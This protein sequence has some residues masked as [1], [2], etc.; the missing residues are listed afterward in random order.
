MTRRT[1]V[2]GA[3]ATAA[4]GALAGLVDLPARATPGRAR[5]PISLPSPQQVR[6]DVQRMV[7]FGPRLT[8]SAPHQHFVAWLEREL[9]AAGARLLPCDDY[10]YERWTAE[11]VGLEV[12]DGPG[13]GAVRVA[14]SFT[15]AQETPAGGVTGPLVYGGVA[16][17]PSID[18]L[19]LASLSTS[20]AGYGEQL[21]SFVQGLLGTLAG[22]TR[23]SI[24]LVDLPL[25]L[26]LVSGI[27]LPLLTHL[28]WE[29]HTAADLLT[30][31]YRRSWILPGLQLPL[32]PFQALG[33][34]GVVFVLDRSYEALRGQ[35]L[36]F[37]GDHEPLPALFVDRDTGRRLRAL[38]GGRPRTRLT[39]TASRATVTTPS[40]TAVIPGASDEVVICNTH[41]DGQGFVEENGGVALV[42][43]ARHFGS[44]PPGERLRR[45]LVFAA[46]PGHTGGHQ[47]PELEGWMGAH[48]DLV[49]RAAAA[50]TIEHLGCTRWQDT[51]DRGWHA[52]GEHELFAAWVTQGRLHD[53]TRDALVRA[54]IDRTA[55][56]RPPVQFGVG[57]AFQHAGVPQIGA[58]AG[59]E[60]L[61]TVS[62]NG[63]MDKFDERLAAR[64]IAWFADVIRRID[65]VSA[66]EL[67]RGDPTLGSSVPSGDVSRPVVCGPGDRFVA[68]G[69]GGAALRVRFYGR[70]RRLRGAVLL[71]LEAT[72]AALDGVTIELRRG[73]R[74]VAR[75][76]RMRIGGRPRDVV[77]RR[78]RG[79]RFALGRYSLLTRRAGT[80]IDRRSVRLGHATR[81]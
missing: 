42:Q 2:R 71:R 25:P 48:R 34:R 65:D 45:T 64:Q 32:A 78:T 22:G 77:L 29:G 73:G 20:L 62:P 41:T 10:A 6:A 36:P 14:T 57:A 59:P 7:D 44:L 9:V 38:A 35:Y 33:A 26:P 81:S 12:L 54:R 1:L 49:R 47:L 28:Q 13:R 46:W 24:L 19:D 23:D 63:D 53:I 55:L 70:R 5:T 50:L 58:L 39:L 8:G 37:F 17:V 66:A 80:I 16:P 11:D 51:A 4:G 67:R 3:A 30:E 52:T 21:A 56:L 68:D 27:F 18:G 40:V 75:T 60:Y 31:E 43:L 61:L 74:L 15:R 76:G 72:G 79:R 69:G